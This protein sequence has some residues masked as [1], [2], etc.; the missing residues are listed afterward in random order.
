MIVDPDNNTLASSLQ[1]QFSL[2]LLVTL[3]KPYSPKNIH[4]KYYLKLDMK[5]SLDMKTGQKEATLLRYMILGIKSLLTLIRRQTNY[6][7]SFTM[8]DYSYLSASQTVVE[9]VLFHFV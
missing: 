4:S 1:P 8:S 6:R 9:T 2:I 7:F 5:Y 3:L